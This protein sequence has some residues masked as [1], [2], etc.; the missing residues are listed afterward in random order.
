MDNFEQI[1]EQYEPMITNLLRRANIYKNHE[2]FRQ[3]AR[4]ALWHAWKKYNPERGPFAPYAYRYMQTTIYTELKNEN[5]FTDHEISYEH[6]KLTATAQLL[7]IKN[8][9]HQEDS[10]LLSTLKNL[11]NENE[12][13]LIVDLYYNGYSYE[14][15]CEKYGIAYY[16]LRKR[17]DRLIQKIRK[18]LKE[19][20]MV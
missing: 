10:E 5:T 8:Q 20:E 13:Q 2:H 3:I 11:L 15:L 16:A 9:N 6:D 12:I 18:Q 14:D 4:V 19:I 1:L 7:E 17:R